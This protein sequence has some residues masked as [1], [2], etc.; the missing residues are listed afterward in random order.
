MKRQNLTKKLT[1]LV[2]STCVFF[3]FLNF[4]QLK[5]SKNLPPQTLS[6]YNFFEG[7][8]ADQIPE[9]DI[10]PYI[11]NTPL[12]SDYAEKLRFVKLPAGSKINY[13][14]ETVFDFPIGTTI[15]KTFY[16]PADFRNQNKG[17][18]LLETRLLIHEETGWKALDYVWNDTQTNAIL[19]VAGDTKSIEYIDLNGKKV[20]QV[21]Q[22]PN[23]NQCKG[24]HNKNEKMTPIGPTARQLNGEFSYGEILEN[25][26]THWEK[27]GILANKPD[28]ENCPKSP[29]WN[30]PET[31]TLDQRTRVYLDI[32][33][34]HCHNKSGPAMTSGLNLDIH[35]TNETALGINKS[36][37]AAGRGSG[38]RNF[39]IVKGKPDK[40]ILIY[41][42]QSAD[43][44]I[45]MPELGRKVIHTEGVELVK[46]WIK[47][48]K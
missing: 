26:L 22:I 5:K 28:L 20:S 11:L 8:I 13:N 7:N 48:M 3:I 14:A 36:P 39:A 16:F 46:E 30:K 31:G 1:L 32:N 38:G 44:G 33:C 6:E 12:F 40:S 18:K 45:A 29:V 25:Q 23:Q 34:G 4:Y 37:V 35:E 43:P 41:R 42:M 2:Q 21:Y 47:T 27:L 19:E 9:K 15:I 10:I 17:R 24:C